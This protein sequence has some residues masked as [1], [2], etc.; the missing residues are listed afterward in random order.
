MPNSYYRRKACI[1]TR[2]V[3]T[4]DALKRSPKT[5]YTSG[6]FF[7]TLNVRGHKPLLGSVV[8]QYDSTTCQTTGAGVRLSALGEKV[9]QCWQNIPKYH[10]N[11][12]VIDAQVM[13]EHFHGLLYLDATPNETLGRV[14]RGFKLGCNKI[15]G[16]QYH[17]EKATLFTRGYNET[18]PI[19]AEEVQTKILYIRANPE[20][21]LIKGQLSDC[22][23]VFR[24]QHSTNWTTDRILQG[25]RHDY[26]LAQDK[27]ALQQALTDIQPKLLTDKQ[28]QLALDYIGKRT[29][30]SASR[31]LPLVCHRADAQRFAEQ[32]AAVMREA[33]HGAVIVSAF[34]SKQEREILRQLLDGCYPVIEIM[35]NGFGKTYK[36]AGPSF[37]ACAQERLL[38]ITPWKYH[39]EK[40][41]LLISRPMCMAMNELT[42][43]IS[44]Q[45]DDWWR[46]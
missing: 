24:N 25:L 12:Q 17:Q 15:Y 46:E 39:Y 32:T 4:L 35:D 6:Y 22:F 14:I 3:H 27:E 9:L 28:G 10:P 11:V 36:P 8:G 37:Y 29:L 13:P 38:Q 34:V 44:G 7:V 45:E 41:S 16:A 18:V 33:A 21:R 42:R 5:D 40:D 1:D 43:L 31:K 19:T 2:M 30:L 23:T 20:R 26:R